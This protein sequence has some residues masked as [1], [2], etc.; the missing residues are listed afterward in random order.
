M[1]TRN[2]TPKGKPNIVGQFSFNPTQFRP[3][4]VV[5]MTTSQ[6]YKSIS[7]NPI[8]VTPQRL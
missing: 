1:Q 3:M 7:F 6:H 5:Q 2:L 8:R 4:K